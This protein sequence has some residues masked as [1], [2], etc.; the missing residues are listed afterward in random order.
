MT[1]IYEIPN[2]PESLRPSR[3]ESELS[4]IAPVARKNYVVNPSF[5]VDDIG[6]TT[7]YNWSI[8]EYSF[9]T[10]QLL[11]VDSVGAV[12]SENA[13]SGFKAFRVNFSDDDTSLV[14]G[15]TNPVNV[16]QSMSKISGKS[17]GKTFY[18]INGAL[19]FYAFAPAISPLSPFAAFNQP[20]GSEHVIDVDVFANVDVNGNPT[21]EFNNQDIVTSSKVTITVPESAY[22]S[23]DVEPNVIGRRKNPEWERHYVYFSVRYVP[24]T[25]T[26]V[27]FSLKKNSETFDG[28]SFVFYLDS[29]Q[30]E[31]FDDD[32]QYAT[33]Y[34]DGNSGS[35]DALSSN[36]YYW[37]GAP[38]KS[39]SIRSIE[40]E[41][42]GVLFNLQN[43]FGF[44]VVTINGLGLPTPEN[45]ITPFV[46]VDGQQYN[47]TG[48]EGREITIVGYIAGGTFL[49]AFR[50]S[51]QLQFLLSNERSD[52]SRPTRF[53]FR[54]PT[55]CK[56]QSQYTYFNAVVQS[57]TV[58]P[59]S[60]LPD[61]VMTIQ[62]NNVDV[63]FYGDNYAY[64]T[65]T[66]LNP[67]RTLRRYEIVMFQ[68]QGGSPIKEY[69]TGIR[70]FDVRVNQTFY[71]Y[72]S[73]RLHTNG[74]CMRGAS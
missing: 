69:F 58:E 25:N 53:Y 4:F 56:I 51:G 20:A 48:I 15:I 67:V 41:S 44:Q 66:A 59:V 60:E 19:S 11:T 31:F 40:A 1:N 71:N 17:N 72:A 68:A 8:G 16:P 32:F 13:Y 65:N 55:D 42:G 50:K 12:V 52:V 73:Y 2:I 61:V 62:L 46:A 5:E 63:Y 47:G 10:N 64:T 24:G 22:F 54:I 21:G 45:Q 28:T 36:G 30:L 29:V 18:T 23:E 43:D 49:D 35:D 9:F 33:S 70:E 27:R 26:F 74:L 37:E 34:F 38:L 6:E 39:V 3:T 7:P 57:I 14:Y